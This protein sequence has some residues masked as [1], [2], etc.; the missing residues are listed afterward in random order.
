M[1][2]SSCIYAKCNRMQATTQCC[3]SSVLLLSFIIN[4]HHWTDCYL[5][6]AIES[7]RLC[8]CV[9]LSIG[10]NISVRVLCELLCMNMCG[11]SWSL[12][13]IVHSLQAENL[14]HI[15]NFVHADWSSANWNRLQCNCQCHTRYTT[16]MHAKHERQT[17]Y[18]V[19]QFV[20]EFSHSILMMIGVP[21]MAHPAEFASNE[22]CVN[23]AK[24][25]S[26]HRNYR[27]FFNRQIYCFCHSSA[28]RS[29]HWSPSH[30]WSF[31]IKYFVC[32]PVA[33]SLSNGSFF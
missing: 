29:G 23:S 17:K 27:K 2:R 25:R 15:C 24:R 30:C 22:R 11:D 12:V 18:K 33:S 26:H 1:K 4:G 31:F 8:V 20:R 19:W 9:R 21:F 5:L 28:F 32:R 10:Q 3:C 14:A 16:S 13:W 6:F 7:I